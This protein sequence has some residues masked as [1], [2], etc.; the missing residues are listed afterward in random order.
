ML[1]CV[2]WQPVEVFPEQGGEKDKKIKPVAIGPRCPWS[3]EPSVALAAP[4]RTPEPT[5]GH[6]EGKREGLLG[7]SLKVGLVS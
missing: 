7:K 6:P 4:A 5:P 3:Q 1:G 2:A